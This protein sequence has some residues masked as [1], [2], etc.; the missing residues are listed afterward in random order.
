MARQSSFGICG[1]CGVRKGKAAMVTHLKQCLPASATQ[2]PMAPV[3][4]LRAQQGANSIYW[5]DVA[6]PLDSKLDQLDGLLRQVW[7]ECCGHLSGFFE[8][9]YDE[10]PAGSRMKQVFRFVGRTVGYQYDFGSTTELTIRLAGVANAAT[11]KAAVVARNEAPV[12]ACN[13]CG[14]PAVHVCSECGWT[15]NG[16]FC[17]KHGRSHEC[18]EEML[19]PV[20]NSPRMGVCGYTG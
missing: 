3:M 2:R 12:W 5:L 8:G 16:F 18:G 4:L 6:A 17:G 10:I 13:A 20:V 19:L 1:L 14:Q 15:G 11:G 9:R 7:L